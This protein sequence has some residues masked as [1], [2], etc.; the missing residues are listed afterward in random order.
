VLTIRVLLDFTQGLP[1]TQKRSALM[2][3]V[4]VIERVT[5]LDLDGDGTVGGDILAEVICCGL[6]L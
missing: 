3:M 1:G 4:D 2:T 6:L 5:G